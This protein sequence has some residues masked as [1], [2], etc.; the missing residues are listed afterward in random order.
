MRSDSARRARRRPP[1]RPERLPHPF[2]EALLSFAPAK[3]QIEPLFDAFNRYAGGI[4]ETLGVSLL[5]ALS[6]A[7][8]A[9]AAWQRGALPSWLC[10]FAAV[11]AALLAAPSASLGR[12]G[13]VHS[14]GGLPMHR[15]AG[16]VITA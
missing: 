1:A 16:A 3:A 13:L 12:R 2:E 15:S 10:A 4:G 14:L 5:M 7:T 11:T 9:G 8:L 6:L